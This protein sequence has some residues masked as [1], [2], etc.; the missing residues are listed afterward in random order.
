MAAMREHTVG[1]R[2]TLNKIVECLHETI[3]NIQV[4]AMN[5]NHILARYRSLYGYV[6]LS[7]TLC[8]MSW[9]DITAP[10]L[11]VVNCLPR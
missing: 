3:V 11:Q 8:I 6:S 4:V 5:R 2:S 7:P 9:P 1:V 10:L